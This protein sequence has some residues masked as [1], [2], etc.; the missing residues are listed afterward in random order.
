MFKKIAEAYEVLADEQKRQ[1]YDQFGEDGLKNSGF[2][3]GDA[4]SIFEH[5]FGGFGGFG[6]FPFGGGRQRNS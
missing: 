3:P 1:T 6:G 4:S 2:N 5:L